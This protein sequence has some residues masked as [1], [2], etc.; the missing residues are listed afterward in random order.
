MGRVILL[1]TSCY[2]SWACIFMDFQVDKDNALIRRCIKTPLFVC[3]CKLKMPVENFLILVNGKRC[4]INLFC[5]VQLV[6]IE[7][8]L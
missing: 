1:N 8:G 2:L 7:Y 4:G 5:N 6:E 3:Y